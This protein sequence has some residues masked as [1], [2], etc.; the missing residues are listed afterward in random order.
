MG[1]CWRR[2]FCNIQSIGTASGASRQWPNTRIQKLRDGQ[3]DAIVLALAGIE[4]LAHKEDSLKQLTTLLK[5]LNYMIM[6]QKVFPLS[7][8]QGALAIEYH[9]HGPI[10]QEIYDML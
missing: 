4:R 1:M 8:S 3:Y 7:A 5:N 6:P 2:F 10:A 9:K